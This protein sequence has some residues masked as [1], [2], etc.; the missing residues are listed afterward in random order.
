MA[1]DV[2]VVVFSAETFRVCLLHPID[3]ISSVIIRRPYQYS[4]SLDVVDIRRRQYLRPQVPV[5]S[6]SDAT[7][8][9]GLQFVIIVGVDVDSH[10]HYLPVGSRGWELHYG[11]WYRAHYLSGSVCLSVRVTVYEIVEWSLCFVTCVT[12]I[13]YSVSERRIS[14]R[15]PTTAVYARSE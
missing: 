6:S 7:C 5:L 12:E 1:V 13:F 3:V 10:Q 8:S 4:S 15:H 2:V 9:F 14:M 11:V